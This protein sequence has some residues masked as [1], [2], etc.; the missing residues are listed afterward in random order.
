MSPA[1]GSAPAGLLVDAIERDFGSLD[2]FKVRFAE[3]G[4]KLFGSGWVWLARARQ[5]GGRLQV[6]TTSGHDIP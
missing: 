1:A 4:G 5:D 3:A 6:Y 2:R